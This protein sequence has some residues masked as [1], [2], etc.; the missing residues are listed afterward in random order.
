MR[1][2]AFLCTGTNSQGDHVCHLIEAQSQ[3]LRLVTR[4]TF[5]AEALAAVGT[6]DSLIPTMF[7]LEEIH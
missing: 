7:A 3:S 2:S 6:A 5:S 1:G 4:S